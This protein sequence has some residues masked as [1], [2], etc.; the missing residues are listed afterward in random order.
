MHRL[1]PQVSR[2]MILNKNKSPFER[3][4]IAVLER[5]PKLSFHW[6]AKVKMWV[7][8]GEMDICD[9]EGVYWNTFQIT[10][11]VPRGYP[12]CVP[13]VA[14]KSYII[15]RDIEW[16]I[17]P[18]GICC[19]DVDHNLKAM[20]KLGINLTSFISDKVYTYFANQLYKLEKHVYAGKEYAHHL[21]GVIQYYLETHG[22]RNKETIVAM[23][24]CL[25]SNNSIGRNDPC[26]CGSG[27]KTKHCHLTSIEVLKTI[28]KEKLATDCKNISAIL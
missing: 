9:T 23:L 5:F 11:L 14:E 4:F 22:L 27:K 17:S 20:A 12:Y 15:P 3:D 8:T 7:I 28:G 16:H 24:S 13:I 2:I 1:L 25:T 10:M 21:D 6:G 18:E 19:L 26:P